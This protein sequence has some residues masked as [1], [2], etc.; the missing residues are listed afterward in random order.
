MKKYTLILALLVS[1]CT[2]NPKQQNQYPKQQN[3]C[4][5]LG[6]DAGVA[7][8]RIA[9]LDEAYRIAQYRTDADRIWKLAS[10]GRKHAIALTDTFVAECER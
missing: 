6:A 9:G 5:A 4:Y 3:Q 2:P 7:I 1:A 10:A 8:G